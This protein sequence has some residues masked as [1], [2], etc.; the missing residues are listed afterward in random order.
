VITRSALVLALCSR[1]TGS[2]EPADATDRPAAQEADRVLRQ[3]ALP[4]NGWT[5]AR[6]VVAKVGWQQGEL[7]PWIGFIVTTLTSPNKRVV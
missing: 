4:A 6:Q 2:R 5:K 1:R 3:L 7:Y